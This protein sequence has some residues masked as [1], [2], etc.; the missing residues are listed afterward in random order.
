VQGRSRLLPACGV[1]LAL[2]FVTCWS[3]APASGAL[4]RTYQVT[5]VDSPE[6]QG[7][8]ANRAGDRF[9]DTIVNAGGDFDGDGPDDLLVGISR[10]GPIRGKVL[11]LNGVSGSLI[12]SIPGPS[13]DVDND[14]TEV[15]GGGDQPTGFGS[16]VS[17]IADIGQC[18][19]PNVNPGAD[20]DVAVVPLTDQAL[21]DG[22]PDF[23]VSAPGLDLAAEGDNLGAVFVI[24]GASGA[25]LKRLRVP[26]ADGGSNASFGRSVL[27]PSGFHACG[28]V[29]RGGVGECAYQSVPAVAQGDLNSSGKPD[30]IVGAPDFNET[31]S[32]S[33]GMC[34]G[35]CSR[36][37]RVYVFYGEDLANVPPS[38]FPP[39]NKPPKTLKNPFAQH[40]ASDVDSRYWPEAMGGSLAPV[41]D[42]GRC[43]QAT[44][45]DGLCPA[46]ARVRSP[47]GTPD[48]IVSVS[49]A[50]IGAIGDAGLAL[51]IDGESGLVLD[52][53]RHPEPQ[54][55]STFG[56]TNSNF[57]ALGD[58]GGGNTLPDIYVPAISQ[59]LAW[60]AQGRGFV[61]AGDAG[62]DASSQIV[63]VLDDPT[64]SN[65]GN[66]GTSSAG[67]GNIA[68]GEVGLDK[69]NEIM[70]GAY[71]LAGNIANDVHIISPL[72][73][74]VLQTIPDPDQQPGSGFGRGLA[75]MGD[76][77]ADGMLD[78]A[79][80]AGGYDGT[81]PTAA[82]RGRI[83]I[84][85]SDNSPA[86]PTPPGNS[87]PPPAGPGGPGPAPTPAQV[88]AGRT[89]ELEANRNRVSPGAQITLRG[90]VEAFT[91]KPRC[92]RNQTVDLQRRRRGT[93]AYKTFMRVRTNAAGHFQ[94]KTRPRSTVFYRAH[95][96]QTTACIGVV[97]P[98]EQ[99]IVRKK[100]SRARR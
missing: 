9:G 11:L 34:S 92:E 6:Q 40:D 65:L 45:P 67:I 96:G 62:G 75:P 73:S 74:A 38:E 77:N 37:G 90:A 94:L 99:V 23:L 78:F 98:R 7:G 80:G 26:P 32:S 1:V 20:C 46:Q 57:P 68:A 76:F 8:A 2:V 44:S 53:Y 71:S 72:T 85:V 52:T 63:S 17:P 41:G 91:R 64:P 14:T 3:V 4:P 97:S 15:E 47:D 87:A 66:F 30:I 36:A 24:D 27:S 13:D 58:V 81:A 69:R 12:R 83:Y 61:F 54:V 43:T 100:A 60:A 28:G 21:L 82:D 79:V 22:L 84:F 5:R 88:L 42:L 51:L 48:F 10:G 56:F 29:G 86:P 35:S 93:L 50:D 95:L 59:T 31:S 49:R 55:G 89:I 39:D 16:A 18:P 33:P 70:V 19:D 25:I